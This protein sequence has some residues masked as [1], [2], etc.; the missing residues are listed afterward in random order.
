MS[1]AYKFGDQALAHFITFAVV[2]WIDVFTRSE[3][4]EIV[5][6]SL[7]FCQ[8]A[9]GLLIHGWCIMPSH[10]HLIVGTQ[11]KP[12]PDILR[13]MKGFTSKAL[14]RAIETHPGESRKEWLLYM[15][16]REGKRNPNNETYQFWQQDNHPIELRTGPI[17][18]QKLDYIHQNPVKAGFVEEPHHWTW[19]SARNYANPAVKGPLELIMIG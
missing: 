12:L 5:L 17:M 4:V 15:L 7:R 3:Y 14:C 16:A 1:N 11:D 9:K 10:V 8:S 18:L 13:D 2:N 19:S 6:D